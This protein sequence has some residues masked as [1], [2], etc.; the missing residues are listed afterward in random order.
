[1]LSIVGLTIVFSL[2]WPDVLA[3]TGS[4]VLELGRS[5]V[6]VVTGQSRPAQ[7]S[8]ESRQSL[9][10]R[11]LAPINRAILPKTI[12]NT[13]TKVAPRPPE[14]DVAQ[15]EAELLGLK[16]SRDIYRPKASMPEI[17]LDQPSDNRGPHL[18]F[19]A[20]DQMEG[21]RPDPVIDADSVPRLVERNIT[22]APLNEAQTLLD[23]EPV[24]I[25]SNRKLR[26]RKRF[27][28]RCRCLICPCL[29]RLIRLQIGL[30]SR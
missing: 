1:M 16:A 5:M 21:D 23:D 25:S 28:D 20:L 8:I 19:A 24:P 9:L 3:A 2:S 7:L 29:I 10:G 27:L 22:I 13:L 12:R 30:F 15:I 14:A 11:F 6:S 4:M 18:D 26:P 17:Y